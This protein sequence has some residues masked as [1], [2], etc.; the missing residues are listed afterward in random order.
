MIAL[1]NTDTILTYSKDKEHLSLEAKK[2]VSYIISLG[3]GKKSLAEK[4]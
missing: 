4:Y 1:Q 3:L 2:K